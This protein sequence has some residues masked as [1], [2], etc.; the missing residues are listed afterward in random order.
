M[1]DATVLVVGGSGYFGRLLVDELCR[2]T[3]CDIVIGGRD[4]TKI[5]QIINASE[6]KNRLRAQAMDLRQPDS[7]DIALSNVEVAICAAGP[8]QSFPLT[9]VERCI[10]QKIPYIDLADARAFVRGVNQLPGARSAA[11]AVCSGWSAVPALS[12][13][14]A[15]I[16]SRGFEEL[17]KIHSQIAPGNKAP[18][19]QSTVSSLLESVGQKHQLWRN[20]KWETASG[21]SEPCGFS[22]PSPI[23]YRL[24]R[25]VDVADYDIFPEKFKAQTVEF[26]VSSELEFLN[27]G[28][29]VLSWFVRRNLAPPL[30]P[31][32]PIFQSSMALFGLFG[33][34]AGAVGVECT[35]RKGNETVR[36]RAS[37]VAE[38]LGHWIP[39]M[40]ATIMTKRIIE[41]RDKFI[42][43][44]D[45]VSWIT[46]EELNRECETRNY[47]LVV[48]EQ[49]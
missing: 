24:G 16:A 23:G 1:S 41:Q 10:E 21:W 28:V 2:F 48:E 3:T 8:F 39:I 26:R 13:A 37:I 40:P 17:H 4:Q 42:G 7:I 27:K 19:G 34:D 5:A 44:Q 45:P 38:R 31:F 9:L 32:T 49:T 20:D 43:L 33:S 22:F 12:G 18:R 46:E 25:L 15:A 6:H 47:K 11:S 35:G 29:D 36:R 30:T 14:L